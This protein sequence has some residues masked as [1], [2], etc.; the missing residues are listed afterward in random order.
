MC[1]LCVVCVWFVCGL[2]VFYV[3]FAQNVEKGRSLPINIIYIAHLVIRDDLFHQII[4]CSDS[5]QLDLIIFGH[6]KVIRGNA[7]PFR[8]THT[9]MHIHRLSNRKEKSITNCYHTSF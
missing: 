8:K 1:G 7:C 4:V 6:I 2:C 5:N 3:W 9:H